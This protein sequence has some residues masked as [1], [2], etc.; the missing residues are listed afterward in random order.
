[1]QTASAR[2]DPRLLRVLGS[3]A[4]IFAVLAAVI[5]AGIVSVPQRAAQHLSSIPLLLGAWA[6]IGVVCLFGGLMWAELGT[7]LPF[8][9]G[10]YLYLT[11]AYGPSLGF[12]YGWK[13][14]LLSAPQ[15]RAALAIIA[16]DHL[17]VFVPLSDQGH[18]MAA[19]SVILLVGAVNYAGVIWAS[20]FQSL[21]AIVK[22]IALLALVLAAALFALPADPTSPEVTTVPSSP[23]RIPAMLLLIFF[24]YEG[25]DRLSYMVGEMKRPRRDLPVALGVG[26]LSTV[27]IYLAV[28]WISFRTL[29]L[30]GVRTSTATLTDVAATFMGEGSRLLVAGLI[31]VAVVGSLSVSILAT[32]RLFLSMAKDGFLPRFF[33][34]VHPTFHTPHRAIMAHVGLAIVALLVVRDFAALAISAT[35]LNVGF[36]ILR[37]HSFLRLRRRKVGEEGCYKAP[38]FPWLPLIFM[39]TLYGV[40][41][42]RLIL[43]WQRAWIDVS[44]VLIAVPAYFLWRRFSRV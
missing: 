15:N 7:R 10:D 24:S 11:S 9:G 5:G 42:G 6:A 19:V 25:W 27:I 29:G 23:G 18:L 1:M 30:E 44:L 28:N 20:R 16:A 41:I 40:L 12:M 37:A 32:A 21:S 33:N 35:F 36:Y 4:G 14:L 43:D 2:D 38:F 17:R 8:S 26:M 3:L 39:L 22:V 13:T 31:I 34:K